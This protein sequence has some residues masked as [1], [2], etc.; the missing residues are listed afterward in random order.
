M[1]A[2]F[3]A[4][5]CWDSVYALWCGS[6]FCSHQTLIYTNKSDPRSCTAPKHLQINNLNIR[7]FILLFLIADS[8]W[9]AQVPPGNDAVL[10]PWRIHKLLSCFTFFIYIKYLSWVHLEELCIQDTKESAAGRHSFLAS[11]HS[12]EERHTQE[13]DSN[14]FFID[15]TEWYNMCIKSK[16][17]P[18]SIPDLF[19]IKYCMSA[20]YSTSIH[21]AISDYSLFL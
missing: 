5:W 12:S 17:K 4:P 6:N 2:N 20:S 9:Y 8:F 18:K 10:H 19:N 7:I 15:S 1:R 11:T 3:P 14:S 16:I 21:H 13:L